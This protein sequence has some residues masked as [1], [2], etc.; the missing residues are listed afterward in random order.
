MDLTRDWLNTVARPY[1][2]RERLVTEV[3]EV[4]TARRTLAVK[5]DAFSESSIVAS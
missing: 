1:A 2:A 4:L 3:I 5:T